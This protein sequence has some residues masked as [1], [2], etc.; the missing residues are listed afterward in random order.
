MK[1]KSINRSPSCH[2]NF[3]GICPY[4]VIIEIQLSQ[5]E[6]FVRI[7]NL[8]AHCLQLE[9]TRGPEKIHHHAHCLLITSAI[10]WDITKW[11][12]AVNINLKLVY[13]LQQTQRHLLFD[14]LLAGDACAE[15]FFQFVD[16]LQYLQFV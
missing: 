4:L 9:K 16:Q 3:P 13:F 15:S 2:N 8:G 10:S 7:A 6:N 5:V 1:Q 14:P 12:K 11:Q